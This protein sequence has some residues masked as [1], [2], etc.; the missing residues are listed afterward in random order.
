LKLSIQEILEASRGQ[1]IQGNSHEIV[2]SISTDS[3]TFQAGEAFLCLIGEKFDGHRFIEELTSKKPLAIIVQKA[4]WAGNIPASIALIEVTDTLKAYGDI[5][6]AW[7]RKFKIPLLAIA[8]SNGKTTTKDMTGLVLGARYKTL[9]TEGNLNNLIGVPK[10]LLKLENHEAA[11][12]EMGMND[13]GELAR[14]TE[15]AEPTAGLI[16]NIG[17]EHLE[18][19]KDLEGVARAEGELFEKLPSGAL[20]LVNIDDP[21]LCKMTSR[22]F[23][24]TFGLEN[25][26]NVSCTAF[27]LTEKGVELEVSYLGKAY[28]FTCPAL[29][30]TAVRNVLAAVAAG[31][32][33]GLEAKEIQK[34][35]QTFQARALR[36]EKILLKNQIVI[37]NDCYNAN[38]SSMD[39]ALETLASLKG[40]APGLAILGEMK[41]L[42][43]FVSE[44]HRQVGQSV[45]KNKIGFLIAV[46]PYAQDV[47]KGALEGGM[48]AL[49]GVA[50]TSQDEVLGKIMEWTPLAQ[51]LLIK[52][53]R[54]AQMEKVTEKIKGKFGAV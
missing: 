50:A 36:M 32:G 15:I 9:V 26:A 28:S 3:R 23:R 5:A 14:L 24:F 38:P 2:R 41:E 30:K 20:A 18:K 37:L 11:V 25:P 43:D 29:G 27:R 39:L 44:G 52:G 17:F 51:Y 10:M 42:G 40:K 34:G 22:A 21:Y 8:G 6:N 1:L 4:H 45:A 48:P 13:F 19:L 7:R 12:I 46:G 31:F 49:H 47:L 53:S 35:L 33:L 54:G 16:T